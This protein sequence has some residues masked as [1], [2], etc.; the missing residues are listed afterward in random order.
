MNE[1][2]FSVSSLPSNKGKP[3]SLNKAYILP[4][5]SISIEKEKSDEQKESE[6]IF[7]NSA[8]TGGTMG[9]ANV[10]LS[11][12]RDKASGHKQSSIEDEYTIEFDSIQASRVEEGNKTGPSRVQTPARGHPVP[13]NWHHTKKPEAKQAEGPKNTDSR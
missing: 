11:K 10:K 8:I 12:S 1:I 9:K 4:Q 7:S 6:P 3:T 13:K 2:Q 5:D